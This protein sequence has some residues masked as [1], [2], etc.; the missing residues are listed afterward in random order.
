MTRMELRSREAPMEWEREQ[1]KNLPNIFSHPLPSEPPLSQTTTIHNKQ[2]QQQKPFGFSGSRG[3]SF[4]SLSSQGSFTNDGWGASLPKPFCQDSQLP[5]GELGPGT[6]NRNDSF[7]FGSRTVGSGD[8][9]TRPQ[10]PNN[11]PAQ[12]FINTCA[13]S[14]LGRKGSNSDAAT[15]ENMEV[16]DDHSVNNLNTKAGPFDMGSLR[17]GVVIDRGTSP[18]RT[19]G[20]SRSSIAHHR[21]SKFL[22]P[23]SLS[24]QYRNGSGSSFWSE[25]DVED[26]SMSDS[27][28]ENNSFEYRE[29][30][31]F[32]TRSQ[33]RV[34]GNRRRF[35]DHNAMDSHR[36]DR[37]SSP[38][39]SQGRVWSENVDLP[40]ILAGYV[41]VVMNSIFVGITL[42]IIY[43]FITT[44]QSD[45]TIRA[46]DEF[47]R[48][49]QIIRK[50][51]ED[52]IANKCHD[53]VPILKSYCEE[54]LACKNKPLP[55]IERS[56]VAAQT[57]ALI[58]NS[59]VNTITYKTM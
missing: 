11:K 19:L 42:Y 18:R 25:V 26:E 34:M 6:Q 24:M 15:T 38:Q 55:R 52:Y 21:T 30:E 17:D 32:S 36:S 40:Y 54:I 4:A 51:D 41:Q 37:A 22:G 49:Q 44:I 10:S 56:T 3:S 43:N 8:S 53:P 57:F 31:R 12:G 16:D 33:S 1:D 29:S 59:F 13:T 5:G 58:F 20:K 2:Q 27:E 50:C 46:E 9:L 28:N 47:N 14:L 39:Q 23:R 7:T 48:Q 35:T 45:V